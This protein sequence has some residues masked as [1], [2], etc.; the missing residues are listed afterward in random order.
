MQ[1]IYRGLILVLLI[2]I[3]GGV[4]KLTLNSQKQVS[5]E[6]NAI[7]T[8]RETAATPASGRAATS[9]GTKT[10]IGIPRP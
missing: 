3:A 6:E 10:L 9:S 1:T 4:I 5:A 7:Q 2:V 8:L